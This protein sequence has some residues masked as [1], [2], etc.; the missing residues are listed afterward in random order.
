MLSVLAISFLNYVVF[1]KNMNS[2]GEML[3]EIDKKWIE[4][5]NMFGDKSRDNDWME[6]SLCSFN[7]STRE[8]EFA[9]ARG[10]MTI[11]SAEEIIS[12]K[13][14]QYPIG[15]WQIEKNRIY[16]G[17]K[18]ILPEN[19]MVYL[20]SDGFKDQIGGEGNKTLKEKKLREFLNELYDLPTHVQKSFLTLVFNEWKGKNIQTDDVCMLGVRL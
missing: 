11:I 16:H 7:R 9:G 10:K 4:T 12:F 2:L 14:D 3:G 20:S 19:S 18:I 5:F 15:G 8:L 13:G 6:I 17:Q 1:A